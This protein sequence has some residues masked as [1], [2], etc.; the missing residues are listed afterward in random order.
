MKITIFY[1]WQSDLP[2]IT[3]RGYIKESLEKAKNQILKLNDN[4]SEIIIDSDS[5]DGLGTPDL[6]NTIFSKINNCDIFLADIS[7][8]NCGSESRKLPNPNV[9]L[10]LGYASSKLGWEKIISVY[11][12]DYGKIEDLPF[13]IRH[14]KPLTYK[15][16]NNNLSKLLE[17]NIQKILENC[18][19]DKKYYLDLKKE[20]DLALQAV[21]ID[22]TTILYFNIISKRY[23]Y[24]SLL[25]MS[26]E[27]LEEELKDKKILGFLIFKSNQQHLTEFIEFFNNQVY[28]NFLSE[29]EKNVLSKVI[30]QLRNLFK[31]LA[32]DSLYVTQEI[33]EKYCIIDTQKINP[34]NSIDSY[35]LVE[36]L[37]DG[38][39]TVLNG[40]TLIKNKVGLATTYFKID[41][42]QIHTISNI[43]HLLSYEIRNWNK[44]TGNYFI[45][46]HRTR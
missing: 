13:D 20:I 26:K 11:N 7:I 9:L 33:N 1:S 41:P 27:K 34:N 2:N 15:K 35:L 46:N 6:V 37:P 3:N 21:L 18:I 45:V 19:S 25:N 10:E 24:N 36:K 40:G 5:R 12:L 32:D 23:D 42:S 30:L 38:K 16:D 22:I 28:M 43:I 14:R 44:A 17:N 39:S 29:I 4:I 8:I 31:F